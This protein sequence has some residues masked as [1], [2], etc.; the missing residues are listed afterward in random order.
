MGSFSLFIVWHL[1]VQHSVDK[2]IVFRISSCNLIPR[3]PEFV[4]P[5]KVTMINGASPF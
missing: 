3:I 4:M 1:V 2:L 5:L